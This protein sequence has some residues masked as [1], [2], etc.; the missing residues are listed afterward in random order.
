[1][2]IACFLLPIWSLC[3]HACS[4]LANQSRLSTL[5]EQLWTASACL[6]SRDS[7]GEKLQTWVVSQ[8]ASEGRAVA[9]AGAE[10]AMPLALALFSASLLSSTYLICQTSSKLTSC[11]GL[12]LMPDKGG[13]VILSTVQGHERSL[14][15]ILTQHGGDDGSKSELWRCM[16][17]GSSWRWCAAA[18]AQCWPCRPLLCGALS[19][20]VQHLDQQ[21]FCCPSQRCSSCCSGRT[22]MPLPFVA[23]RLAHA[24]HPRCLKIQQCHGTSRAKEQA[25]K[26]IS[27]LHHDL[28]IACMSQGGQERGSVL[29][30]LLAKLNLDGAHLAAAGISDWRPWLAA[31]SAMP[32]AGPSACAAPADSVESATGP[33]LH[34]AVVRDEEPAAPAGEFV[35]DGTKVLA[36]CPLCIA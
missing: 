19:A 26:H 36:R 32:P 2:Y 30:M 21:I 17:A 6:T 28:L 24:S 33:H 29:G 16:H 25:C 15:I 5:P 7:A 20:Y 34:C 9:V 3:L 23:C 4:K 22:A 31:L 8:V 10:A 14:H 13:D 12:R 35:W 11:A 1:M 18:G 27:I